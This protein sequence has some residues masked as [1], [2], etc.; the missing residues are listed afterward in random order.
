M[1]GAPLRDL[2]DDVLR[3]AH[4]V[5]GGLPII[6]VG[7]IFSAQDAWRKILAGASLVQVYTG[8]VYEGAGLPRRINQDL[9]LLME[10]AGVR[11]LTEVVGQR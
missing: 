8:F 2:A 6:G 4:A 3:R 7:G 1:S 11:S 9:V 10:Q 5:A